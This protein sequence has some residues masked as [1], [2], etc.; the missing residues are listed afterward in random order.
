M[1]G[2]SLHTEL[3][4]PQD[5]GLSGLLGLNFSWPAH[6]F[7]LLGLAATAISLIDQASMGNLFDFLY[8]T[9]IVL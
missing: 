9:T 1:T 3:A 2:H 7:V 5:R 8:G 4:R 6:G